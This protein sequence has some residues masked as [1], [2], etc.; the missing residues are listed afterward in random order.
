MAEFKPNYAASVALTF[1]SLNSLA[2]SAT[3]INGAASA[4]VDNSTTR[5]ADAIVSGKVQMSGTAPTVSKQ[6][7]IWI[8]A[9]HDDTPTYPDVIDGTNTTD[10]FPDEVSRNAAL[11][12]AK[13]VVIDATASQ[14][15]WIAPFSIVD[16]LGYMPQRWGLWVSQDTGQTLAASGH[17]FRYQG[18]TTESL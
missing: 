16:K 2:T 6:V 5:Y 17:E 8:Y 14:V 1:S 9:Q 12:L 11:V 18:V 3:R 10:N 7:D 15:Y 13:V 4:V